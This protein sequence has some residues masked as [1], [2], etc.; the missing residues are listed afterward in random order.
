MDAHSHELQA[1]VL[2]HVLALNTVSNR[3]GLSM[4]RQHLS[5]HARDCSAVVE[6]TTHDLVGSGTGKTRRGRSLPRPKTAEFASHTHVQIG[7][8]GSHRST[9]H[10]Q[11]EESGL[12][13]LPLKL[14]LC[15]TDVEILR[16]VLQ[17]DSC[18]NVSNVFSES[19]P[20]LRQSQ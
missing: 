12:E 1:S 9:L 13:S 14:N 7:T 19:V 10:H 4:E 16:C 17:N 5:P 20:V 8:V 2:R 18:N 15:A 11:D 3:V 6:E